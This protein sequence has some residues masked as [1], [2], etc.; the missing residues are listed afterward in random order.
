[1]AIKFSSALLRFAIPRNAAWIADLNVEKIKNRQGREGR[2]EKATW[3]LPCKTQIS[4]LHTIN[5]QFPNV[6]IL[7]IS[8]D[9]TDTRTTLTTYKADNNMDWVVGRDITK[10]G[11]SI[12]QATSIPKIIFFN[13]EGNLK[14]WQEGVADAT[15]LSSWI[16]GN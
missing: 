2:Q 11:A 9:L 5:S 12:Y 6:H 4:H 8:I 13:A 7:S 16:N 10:Q 14:H 15:T 1:M 3:C